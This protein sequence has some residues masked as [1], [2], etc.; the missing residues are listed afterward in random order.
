MPKQLRQKYLRW[1]ML[2]LGASLVSTSG[3]AAW[4]HLFPVV[5]SKGWGYQVFHADIPRVS[6]LVRDAQGALFISQEFSDGKGTILKRA[7]D[8]SLK[9]MLSGLSKPD[10]LALYDGGVAVGQEG[11]TFP[12]LLLRGD[13]TE[14]LFGADDVEGLASDGHFLYAIE[15]KKLGRL[16]RFDPVSGEVVTLRDGLDEGEAITACADGRL[17]YTEKAKGWVKQWQATGEDTLVQAG[18]NAPGF[19][20][21]S[22]DGLWITEDATH[23]AR[24]LL[25][26]PA[27]HLQVILNHM[28]AVQTIVASTDGSY[29][30]AEQ[31]R[32]RILELTRLPNGS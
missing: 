20:L 22:A 19:L 23:M 17:F 21:C 10:G 27:G 5:A 7:T 28:R 6:A 26:D 32:D 29:L 14:S 3:Y 25:L 24:V 4:R 12:V 15:D 8:G 9:T 31:G 30:V 16:L 13:R 2:V 11:G 1:L 18:L